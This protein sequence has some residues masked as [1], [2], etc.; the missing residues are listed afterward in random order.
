M[1]PG[2]APPDELA[3]GRPRALSPVRLSIRESQIRVAPPSEYPVACSVFFLGLLLWI[4]AEIMAFVLVADKI[5]FLWALATLLL[6]SALGPMI[7]RRVGLGVLRNVQVR[8]ARGE[9]PTEELL[10]G[11]MV[12]LAGILICV[13]GFVGDALGLFL[14][15]RPVRQ[16]VIRTFGFALTRR[17]QR[18]GTT[19]TRVIQVRGTP[20]HP[21]PASPTGVSGRALGPGVRD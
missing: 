19:R 8:L 12:L 18:M 20:V 15:I 6:V 3:D 7:I 9:L 16:L 21:D 4:G 14:M 5:G 2:A 17:V 1:A 11:V 13:P 10:G